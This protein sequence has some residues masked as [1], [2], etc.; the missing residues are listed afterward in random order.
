[1]AES[2][3]G[4]RAIHC[5]TVTTYCTVGYWDTVSTSHWTYV[6]TSHSTAKRRTLA[7]R[8]SVDWSAA[9]SAEDVELKE[10]QT[11]TQVHRRSWLHPLFSVSCKVFMYSCIINANDAY[12]FAL[13]FYHN[14]MPPSVRLTDW[15]LPALQSVTQGSMASQNGLEHWAHCP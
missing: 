15:H 2:E 13:H 3:Q 11:Q 6:R 7:S 10:G 5:C 12:V 14:G 9:R 8:A 1:M 4:T